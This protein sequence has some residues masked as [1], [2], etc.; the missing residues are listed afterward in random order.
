MERD[1]ALIRKAYPELLNQSDF[2]KSLMWTLELE[3][4]KDGL[5]IVEDARKRRDAFMASFTL[6]PVD[7]NTET[8]PD[9][10]LTEIIEKAKTAYQQYSTK[11]DQDT[12]QG[13]VDAKGDIKRY[14]NAED[15]EEYI[16]PK[17]DALIRAIM[18][19]ENTKHKL[20]V[21]IKEALK[22]N[23]EKVFIYL[24]LIGELHQL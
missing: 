22:N 2:L 17:L 7:E 19:T 8:L 21:K 18:C 9:T 14:F 10:A 6:P 4:Q 11:Y 15:N 5:Q 12:S 20:D 23:E 1:D 24:D 13:W 16:N 3:Y